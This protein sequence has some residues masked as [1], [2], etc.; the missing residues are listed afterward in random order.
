MIRLKRGDT[1][2]LAAVVLG[3]G[4]PVVG[5]IGAWTIESQIRTTGGTL[6]DTLT[7]AITDATACTYTIDES[8]AG[9]T[10]AWPVGKLE[11]DI[12]YTVG[13]DVISTETA[14][15]NLIKDVTR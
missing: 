15:I 11:M 12:Q 9:V 2:S 5:G 14:Q 3:D 7:I 4:V 10:E 13:G 8:A 6:V 1:F